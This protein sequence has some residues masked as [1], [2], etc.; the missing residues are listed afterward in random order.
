[1]QRP[2]LDVYMLGL[3]CQAA[4]R[5]TCI[6]RGVGCV[7]ASAR[8]HVLAIA[9]NGVASGMPHCSE[10]T[11]MADSEPNS[12][13][14]FY[15]HRCAG[16][17]LPPGQDSCEAIHAEQNALLQCRDPWTIETSYQTLSP[18]KACV[19]LLLGTSCRRLVFTEEHVDPVPRELWLR[20]GRRWEQATLQW[21]M[22][23][24]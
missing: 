21:P 5:T 12:R 18:C 20:A 17:D 14:L 11:G 8:G 2:T 7:L 10:A 3:A 15:G 24:R 9:Y 22:V 19:K 16:H 13:V 6:R 23:T 4:L 1:V